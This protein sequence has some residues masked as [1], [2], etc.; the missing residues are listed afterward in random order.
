MT[1]EIANAFNANNYAYVIKTCERIMRSRNLES[2]N[3]VALVRASALY[4]TGNLEAA[5]EAVYE[6]LEELSEVS[7]NY[8]DNKPALSEVAYVN[9]LMLE[10]LMTTTE[11]PQRT[12]RLEAARAL[13]N[14]YYANGWINPGDFCAFRHIKSMETIVVEI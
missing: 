13:H 10:C 11:G 2:H 7:G 3:F 1:E 6:L 8:E 14:S 5:L 12:A 4:R 9:A